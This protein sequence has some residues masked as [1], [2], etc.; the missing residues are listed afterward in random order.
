MRIGFWASTV[1]DVHDG[2]YTAVGPLPMGKVFDRWLSHSLEVRLKTEL[3][4]PST[5]KAYRSIIETHLRPAFAGFRSDQ[6]SAK[7]LADWVRDRADDIV[8]GDLSPKTYNNIL[9]LLN[10]VLGWSRESGQR[11]LAHDPL[12]EVKRLPRSKVERDYLEP[13][14]IN[15]LLEAFTESPDDTL[16]ALAVY[17]G[18]RRGELFGLQWRD[19]D[20]D[21]GQIRVERSVYQ[22]SITSPKTKSSTR[23][24]D[25][26]SS[27]VDRLVAYRET[28]PPIVGDFVFRT[29]SGSP[30]DPDN[31]YKR[32]F[33]PA[34]K[35]AELRPI[36]LHCLRHTYA[37]LLINQGESIKYVS[38]QLGH[39]SIQITAD[40]Y[41]HLFRETS[42]AAMRRLDR[43]IAA[44]V[45]SGLRVVA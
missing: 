12:T 21:A 38:K 7:V 6:L 45:P 17:S 13:A 4:K 19:L 37:S 1:T 18:L 20:R 39:A 23:V 9:N 14:E 10:A 11:Y 33:V 35:R 26:P 44:P 25:L 5:A 22:G 41:G 28:H 34:V 32:R 30:I 40:L 42:A 15:E 43:L 8:T 3:L 2:S 27:I 31:W 16:V 24:V 29:D 36:G